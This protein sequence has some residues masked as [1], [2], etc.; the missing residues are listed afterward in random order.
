MKKNPTEWQGM[1]YGILD[2][3]RKESK[4]SFLTN[5]RIWKTKQNQIDWNLEELAWAKINL[6]RVWVQSPFD[7][8]FQRWCSRGGVGHR[9]NPKIKNTGAQLHHRM[10]I[11]IQ[12]SS[13]ATLTKLFYIF[14]YP[15]FIFVWL[16]TFLSCTKNKKKLLRWTGWNYKNKICPVFEDRNFIKIWH[17]FSSMQ[18]PFRFIPTK[19]IT[20]KINLKSKRS[21]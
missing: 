19:W 11:K 1:D 4:K 18:L 8:S 20:L 7:L 3:R 16:K 5:M 9:I 15:F 12:L 17:Q 21:K 14:I 2:S 10:W 13:L 6:G